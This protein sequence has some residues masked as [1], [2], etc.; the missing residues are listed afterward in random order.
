MCSILNMSKE[1]KSDERQRLDSMLK[2]MNLLFE[3]VQMVNLSENTII[4]LLGGFRY[5]DRDAVDDVDLQKSIRYFVDNKVHPDDRKRC[6][7]F[8]ASPT[9]AAR[10]E[11][12]KLGYIADVFRIRKKE[13]YRRCEAYIMM[14]PG[15]GGNEY[16]FCVKE[17]VEQT[18]GTLSP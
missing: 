9:L 16:L 1:S 7:I 14:I 11:S 8:L 5:L 12:T 2:E 3:S 18:E 17:C 6:D 10:V 13:G 4:P 15:T